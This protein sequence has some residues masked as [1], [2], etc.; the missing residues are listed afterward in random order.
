MAD[1]RAT[2]SKYTGDRQIPGAFE[3]E[4]VTRRRFMTGTA[5][6]AGAVM[7]S[8]IALPALGFALGPIF[9][10]QE[11]PWNAVGA[12]GEFPDDTYIPKVVTIVRGIGQAGKTT[13][14]IRRR[15]PTIDKEPA[16]QYNQFIAISTR[17]MHAGCPVRFV[18]AAGRFICP[19]HGGVYDFSGRVDGGPPVRPLDRF[20]TRVRNGQLEVGPRFS[21]NDELKRFSPRDPGQPLDGIG[22]Y[23][24]PSR[25]TMRKIEGT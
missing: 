5:N 9:E 10:E 6:A 7:F 8:A 19:C 11:Q 1:R 21:V 25:P 16:D 15:N 18:E 23:V 17:C 4:T 3:G 20:Y 2:K 12:Q 24:Y 22:Q 13:V 14:Y